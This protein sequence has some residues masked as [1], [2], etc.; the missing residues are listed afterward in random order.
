MTFAPHWVNCLWLILPVLIWNLILGPRITDPRIT[1]D[2]FSPKW[3]LMAENVMRIFVF[4]LPL[5]IPLTLTTPIQKTS[6]VIYISGTLI[7]FAS[8]IPLLFTPQSAWS[9][10]LIGLL[11]PRI[12]PFFTFLGIALIG[13][14]WLYGVCIVLFILLHTFHG[15]QNFHHL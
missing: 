2:E 6:L 1:S 11:A 10:S 14:S 8:W 4:A 9:N 7:Y 5:L 3:L 13:E 15:V 12:S